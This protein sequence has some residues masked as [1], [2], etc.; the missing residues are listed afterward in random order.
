LSALLFFLGYALAPTAYYKNIRWLVSYPMWIVKKLD[1]LSKKAWNPVFLFIFLFSMN[2]FSLL[3][4][5]LSAVIP[6]LPFL[7]AIWTGINIGVVTYHT[8]EG[9][10]YYTALINP[11]A[12][13]EL[14]AAFLTFSM[15][16]QYNLSNL[17]ITSLS[18]INWRDVAFERYVFLFIIA[19]LPILL[20][21]GIIE[22]YLIHMSKKMEGDNDEDS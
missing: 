9:N 10:F 8:L 3:V 11:V 18:G 14:P 5:L 16:I 7:F 4:D 21:A 6:L 12:F 19:V 15:A 22:T 17:G 13:F 20:M 1:V 2:S